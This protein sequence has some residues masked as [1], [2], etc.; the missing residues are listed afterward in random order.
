MDSL[1]R[2]HPLQYSWPH[3][4]VETSESFVKIAPQSSVREHTRMEAINGPREA[5]DEQG[6]IEVFRYF[7]TSAVD[8]Q[9]S[10]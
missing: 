8:H 9:I 5:E 4:G 10:H 3:S 2:R 1:Y 6:R 7:L